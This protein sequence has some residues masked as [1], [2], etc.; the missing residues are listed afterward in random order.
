[1]VKQNQL[2]IENLPMDKRIDK[3]LGVSQLVCDS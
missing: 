2:T 1:M 3:Y